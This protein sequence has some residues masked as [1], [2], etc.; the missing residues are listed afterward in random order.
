MTA[1]KKGDL[2]AVEKITTATFAGGGRTTSIRW[3]LGIVESA[4]RDGVVRSA[5]IGPFQSR[6]AIHRQNGA[7]QWIPEHGIGRV[8][9]APRASVDVASVPSDV[10]TA[11]YPG[12]EEIREAV[13]PYRHH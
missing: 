8:V 11:E 2:V 13:G 4:T 7:G 9:I 12:V 1:G 5:R 3:E 6:C 10:L